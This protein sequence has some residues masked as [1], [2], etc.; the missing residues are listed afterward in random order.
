DPAGSPA[1]TMK[2][3]PDGAWAR[4]SLRKQPTR[5]RFYF[6]MA[7]RFAPLLGARSAVTSDSPGRVTLAVP[8]LSSVGFKADQR[9]NR[10]GS[11]P[12]V[13]LD[14]AWPQIADGR[15]RVHAIVAADR[16]VQPPSSFARWA[17]GGATP[18]PTWA[19]TTMFP[20]VCSR[21]PHGGRR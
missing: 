14:R 13:R 10:H 1:G 20:T 18:G 6:V 16:F 11:A 5:E 4:T 21:T 15:T 12:R 3:T 2:P 7:D 19:P 9:V 8:A 17:A